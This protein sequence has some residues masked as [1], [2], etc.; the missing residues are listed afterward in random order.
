M[1]AICQRRRPAWLLPFCGWLAVLRR[2]LRLRT[3]VRSRQIRPAASL[4]APDFRSAAGT[5]S[6]RSKARLR[7]AFCREAALP[8]AARRRTRQPLRVPPQQPEC[9]FTGSTPFSTSIA[10]IAD[11][12]SSTT[13]ADN[14]P[15]ST[16]C[17]TG[18]SHFDFFM[19][20]PSPFAYSLCL[21]TREHAF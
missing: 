20:H 17:Q 3:G 19:R 11:S 5:H 8:S 2:K 14:T 1:Q 16:I 21:Y 18:R 10:A 6:P 12:R 13:S 4:R 9:S 7:A 15:L